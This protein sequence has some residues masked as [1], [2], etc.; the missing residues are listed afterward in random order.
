MDTAPSLLGLNYHGDY[1]DVVV[2]VG[3]FDGV[4]RGHQVILERLLEQARRH[5]ARAVVMTFAPHP[6]AVLH[7]PAPMLLTPMPQRL[8]RF[9]TCGADAAV[10]VPFTAV[11]AARSPDDFVRDLLEAH[12]TRV[13][14]V[15]VG[16]NWRFGAGGAGHPAR[17]AALAAAR[18]CEVHALPELLYDQRP[19]SST[20]VRH[21]IAHGRMEVAARLLGRPYAVEGL[22]TR[23]QGAGGPLLACPTANVDYAPEQLLPPH[24][25]YAA[26]GTL[27]SGQDGVRPWPGIAY[28]GERPTLRHGDRAPVVLE[29]HFFFAPGELYGRRLEV[30]FLSFVRPDRSFPS[31][32]ELRTQI[33][34]DIAHV[35]ALLG[36]TD[37]ARW[38]ERVT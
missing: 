7:P 28:V 11:L 12:G 26:M 25:V 13:H 8:G 37:P 10:V 20:R 32:A 3:V 38:S 1:A 21:D 34:R 36:T 17:L 22:V 33:G 18:N 24:G 9:A 4:H 6:R 30:Q 5:R 29:F 35:Q 15:C 19:V 31:V 14:A 27:T 2:A 23:G 16:D